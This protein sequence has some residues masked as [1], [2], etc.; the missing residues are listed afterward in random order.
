MPISASINKCIEWIKDY[1]K[2]NS[3]KPISGV[4]FYQPSVATNKKENSSVIHHCFHQQFNDK[5]IEWKKKHKKPFQFTIPVGIVSPNSSNLVLSVG[6]ENYK[7]GEKYIYQSGHHYVRAKKE[8]DSIVGEITKIASGVFTHLVVELEGR[9][10]V[11]SG[12]FP[13]RDKLLIL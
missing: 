12:K 9:E 5:F 8:E 4:I 2:R 6:N 1:F 10:F 3:N 13:P 11:L 7:I